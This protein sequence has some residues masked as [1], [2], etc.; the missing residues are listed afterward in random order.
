MRCYCNDESEDCE[1]V[2]VRGKG[3]TLSPTT[4]DFTFGF[5]HFV[6]ALISFVNVVSNLSNLSQR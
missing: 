6:N 1:T 3:L 4:R 2:L 5:L